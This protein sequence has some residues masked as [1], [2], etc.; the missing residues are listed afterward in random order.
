MASSILLSSSVRVT[1]WWRSQN[2]SAHS[3]PR[4]SAVRSARSAS[5]A[6]MTEVFAGAIAVLMAASPQI[7]TASEAV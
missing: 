6:E 5:R 4:D 7:R 2:S 3:P 1:E